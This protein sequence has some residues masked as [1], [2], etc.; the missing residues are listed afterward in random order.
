MAMRYKSDGNNDNWNYYKLRMSHMTVSSIL[1]ENMFTKKYECLQCCNFCF[2]LTKVTE[3]QTFKLLDLCVCV[4][5]C[6][7]V[8]DTIFPPMLFN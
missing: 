6:V 5:V 7:C 8:F 3:I 1:T 4:C 2:Y